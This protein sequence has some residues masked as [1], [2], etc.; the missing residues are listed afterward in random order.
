MQL[1]LPEPGPLTPTCICSNA[2][3][4]AL[5]PLLCSIPQVQMSQPLGTLP[6]PLPSHKMVNHFLLWMITCVR[7]Q[8]LAQV[9]CVF[10][11][12]FHSLRHP[13]QQSRPSEWKAH[14][15]RVLSLL[16]HGVLALPGCPTTRHLVICK[17]GRGCW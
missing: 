9:E 4:F 8:C 1:S 16:T 17:K 12:H 13:F 11:Q 10:H 7:A 14:R 6:Q 15:G 2:L 5:S 3:P